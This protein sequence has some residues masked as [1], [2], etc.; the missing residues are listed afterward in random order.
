MRVA[1]LFVFFFGLTVFLVRFAS[2]AEDFLNLFDR[3]AGFLA[4]VFFRDS[5]FRFATAFLL[6]TGFLFATGFR[7]ATV[8][9]L[10]R[11]FFEVTVVFL[12]PILVPVFVPVFR[13]VFFRDEGFFPATAFLLVAA[14]LEVTFL[15]VRER[16]VLLAGRFFDF[17]AFA[18]LVALR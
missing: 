2:V 9:S 10:A 3:T 1:A 15:V 6:V 8:F 4:A 14:V 11:A 12:I 18:E 16:P 7:L 13:P 17:R 5:A